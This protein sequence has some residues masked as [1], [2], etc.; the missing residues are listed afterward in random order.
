MARVEPTEST[1][2]CQNHLPT[3][4][5]RTNLMNITVADRSLTFV[6]PSPV[7]VW[8]PPTGGGVYIML[9][10]KGRREYDVLYVGETGNFARRRIGPRHHAWDE[11]VERAGSALNI[12]VTTCALRRVSVG[13]RRALEC[14]LIEHFDPPVNRPT[15]VCPIYWR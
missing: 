15:I 7:V 9:T 8:S 1:S 10:P 6:P 5:W 12:H 13:E 2:H 14:A 11:C 3:R 4:V